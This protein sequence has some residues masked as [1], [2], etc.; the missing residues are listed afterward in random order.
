MTSPTTTAELSPAALGTA[1]G[2]TALFGVTSTDPA[3][4][5]QA[6]AR[7]ASPDSDR[8]RGQ[9]AGC[10]HCARPIRLRGRVTRHDRATGR[11]LDTVYDTRAEPDGVLLVRCGNRRAAVCPSCAREYAADVWHLLHAG[12]AGGKGVPE[13][14]AARPAV[15]VTLTAPGFGLVHATRRD[16]QGRTA[17][18]RPR[19]DGARALCPHG[20]PTWCM[21]VHAEDDSRLGTP[22]CQACY[23]YE[24]AVW[25]NATAP[26]LWRRFTTYLPRALAATLRVPQSVLRQRVRVQ[27]AKVAEFQRRGLVH[28]HAVLRL[29]GPATADRPYPP[30]THPVPVQTLSEAVNAAA[31][32][33]SVRVDPW[34]QDRPGVRLRFGRQ[35]DVTP[36]RVT[37]PLTGEAELTPERVAAYIA[38]YATKS[39]EDFG[40]P[41]RLTR[42]ADLD[43]QPLP[44]TPHVR[45]MVETVHE[46]ACVQPRLGRWLH[47]L[48]FPGHFATKSR[49][50]STTLGA[51]R[52]A[53]RDHR[54]RTA[55]AERGQVEELPSEEE[56]TLVIR[57]WQFAGVGYRTTGDA[58]LAAAAA[59]R[60]RERA[61]A[62]RAARRAHAVPGR[63]PPLRGGLPV[64][65]RR[66]AQ[67][68]GSRVERSEITQ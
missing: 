49:R 33:V 43:L 22:L 46:L 58:E 66:R 19:R 37:D 59:A 34:R 24:A 63:F 54:Q 5:G 31:A 62:A 60:A 56:T 13:D 53:R 2:I 14:V 11:R 57:S 36:L 8:W 68:R 25:F 1:L 20:R 30:P 28:F 21:A 55:S 12:L 17:R 35:V 7:I 18:C 44:V 32:A 45:R 6:V 9:V 16:R 50:Y 10:G 41:S 39:A 42:P 3:V 61:D 47:M 40:L 51:L 4:V 64:A 67:R 65:A 38:K 48:G 52:Q 26:E 29:D 15:F 27:Y 23:D